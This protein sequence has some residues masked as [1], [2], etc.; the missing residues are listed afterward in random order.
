MKYRNK[1]RRVCIWVLRELMK[2]K[3]AKVT[4]LINPPAEKIEFHQPKYDRYSV[5]ELADKN[6]YP[7]ELIFEAT[8]M[9][10]DNGH[11]EIWSNQQNMYLRD[12]QAN[13]NGKSA[14]KSKFY[15]D[16]IELYNNDKYF[17]YFRWVL[18][19]VAIAI[20]ILSLVVATC[21]KSPGNTIQVRQSIQAQLRPDT[22]KKIQP[23]IDTS[24]RTK[25][26]TY[27]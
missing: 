8:E 25:K 14:L 19:I 12:I 2:V 7:R 4:G 17:R 22:A 26:D 24:R 3:T 9:L 10:Y 15:E 18:P 16:E 11:I 6:V 23:L 20:S 27:P 21:N 13:G 5:Q 1:L